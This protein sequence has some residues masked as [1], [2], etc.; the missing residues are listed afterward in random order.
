M[1]TDINFKIANA[2][3]KLK[4]SQRICESC[5]INKSHKIRNRIAHVKATEK[6]ELVHK[7]RV[8]DDLIST[9][10]EK[11]RYVIV[12]TNDYTDFTIVYLLKHRFDMKEALQNYFELMQTQSTFMRRF[13]FDND[14]KYAD[15][16]TQKIIN[17]YNII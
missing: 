3:K 14:D 15:I 12:M 13:C 6:D 9:F 7:D 17:E 8:D 11:V 4:F 5:V 2:L 1:S 10:I 16:E